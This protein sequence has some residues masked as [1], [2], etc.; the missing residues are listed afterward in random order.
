MTS[1]VAAQ[2]QLV[3]FA[4]TL[5]RS[6]DMCKSFRAQSTDTYHEWYGE[7]QAVMIGINPPYYRYLEDTARKLRSHPAKT[8]NESGEVLHVN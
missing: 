7:L 3:R 4:N 2:F 1:I 6:I 5:A 8:M